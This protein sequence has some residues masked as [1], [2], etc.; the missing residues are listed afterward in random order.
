MHVF[1]IEVE[2]DVWNLYVGSASSTTSNH[3]TFPGLES[4]GNTRGHQGI[5][6]I[7][8]VFSGLAEWVSSEY[9]A[10][11]GREVLMMGRPI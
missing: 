5:F 10:W 6:K 3:L 11:F 7:V 9:R 1:A 2:E 8:Q 4:V